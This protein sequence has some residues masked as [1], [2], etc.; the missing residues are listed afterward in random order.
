ML[1]LPVLWARS[2]ARSV[3][4]SLSQY[5]GRDRLRAQFDTPSPSTL[6]EIGCAL[7]SI[8]PLPVLWERAGES[9]FELLLSLRLQ[10][11]PSGPDHAGLAVEI[12]SL[13]GAVHVELHV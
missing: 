9:G 2:V 8:L 5:S 12:A 1:P 6:G 7:S 13:A 10:H 4:H 3:R 11:R